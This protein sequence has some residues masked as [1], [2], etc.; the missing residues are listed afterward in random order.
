MSGTWHSSWVDTGD[1]RVVGN[2]SGRGLSE[3]PWPLASLARRDRRHRT[4]A[5]HAT[6]SPLLYW[7]VSLSLPRAFT[8]PSGSRARFAPQTPLEVTKRQR[9]VTSRTI[10]TT[11]RRFQFRP[12]YAEYNGIY[13]EIKLDIIDECPLTTLGLRESHSEDDDEGALGGHSLYMYVLAVL[14]CTLL[15]LFPHYGIEQ[16]HLESPISNSSTRTV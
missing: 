14:N 11:S 16:H 15:L 13:W 8:F 7:T 4:G 10:A 9:G 3:I 1:S 2:D 5:R 12:K 6:Q